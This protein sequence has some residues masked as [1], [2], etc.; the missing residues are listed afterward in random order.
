MGIEL[1]TLGLFSLAVAVL[2]ITPGADMVFILSMAISGGARA[3]VVSILGVATG[4][5]CHVLMA[6]I[7][8][9]ALIAASPWLF[10][11]M[12]IVGALYIAWIGLSI[13]GSDGSLGRIED[14]EPKPLLSIFRQGVMTNLLN[15]KAII[16]TLSFIPQFIP[17]QSVN[18]ATQMLFLGVILVIIMMAIEMPLAIFAGKI[19]YRLQSDQRLRRFINRL[20]GGTLVVLSCYVLFS[21]L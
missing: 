1:S 4:A 9:A 10:K 15:P 18:K 13:M 2:I 20:A 14:Q 16:F 12:V 3:G 17:E 5:F 6:V 21:R 8:L 7:G 19:G 11:G